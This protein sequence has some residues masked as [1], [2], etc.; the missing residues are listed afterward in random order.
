M[1]PCHARWA[2]FLQELC[3]SDAAGVRSVL[4]VCCGTGLMAAEL[5]ALGYRVS[6]VD[7]SAQMLARARRRLGPDVPL[8][9]EA[10][11]HLTLTGPF[12]AAVSTLDGL[13]H[14]TPA[15]LGPAFAAIAGRLRPGGWL[16]ADL[17]TDAMMEFARANAIVEGQ[18]GGHRFTITSTVDVAGRTCDARIALRDGDGR[19]GFDE[20]HRQHFFRDGDVRA[21]LAGAGFGAVAVTDEYTWEPV[22]DATLRATWIAR[23]AED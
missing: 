8:V 4:D 15:E 1:D 14:L 12:D 13:N 19:G 2:A 5:V 10:L 7:A 9:H 20:V 16:V 17:H 23:R 21:A 22:G 11:P 3:G 6:G 18:S